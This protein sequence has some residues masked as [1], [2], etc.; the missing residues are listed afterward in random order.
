VAKWPDIDNSPAAP[1]H[2]ARAKLKEDRMAPSW[3]RRSI[4]SGAAALGSATIVKPSRAAE[5]KFSQYH[6][7]AAGGTL[8]QNLTAM[9]AAIPMRSRC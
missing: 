6:N 2:P 8:H 5:Y 3:T 1:P 7:Q 4:L 9:W